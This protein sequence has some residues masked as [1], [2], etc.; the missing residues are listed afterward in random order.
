MFGIRKTLSSLFSRTKVDEELFESLEESLLLGDVGISATNELITKLRSIAKKESITDAS[1]LKNRLE[2]LIGE[3]LYPLEFNINPLIQH[4]PTNTP[5]IWLIVGVNGAG[6]TTTIG[7]L[8]HALQKQNKKILLAAGDTFRAAAKEQLGEWGKRNNVD[9]IL[10]ATGD[11]ATVAH[12]AIGAALARQ[13]DILIIDTAGRLAT[14]ANLMEELKKVK[15]VIQ[16]L[17]PS[18]PHQ[19]ILV[20]DGN[21]GQ[22]GLTQVKAFHEALTLSS[23]I[24]TKVDGTA[25]GGVLC[26]IAHFLRGQADQ[27]QIMGLGIGEKV[28]QIEPFSALAFA[29]ELLANED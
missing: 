20:L 2:I 5:E 18:A 13:A 27:P 16:K 29:K 12:D 24:I 1:I 21:T 22:N 19:T 7:K 9:V 6:K 10:Q 25:K 8:C 23:L 11:A 3:L 15:R 4:I 26:A 28:Q 17:I 14:Q